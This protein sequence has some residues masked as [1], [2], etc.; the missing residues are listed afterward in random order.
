MLIYFEEKPYNNLLSS[1]VVDIR[2]DGKYSTANI[3]NSKLI[4]IY[5]SSMSVFAVSVLSLLIFAML[6]THS[7][8]NNYY[9][10]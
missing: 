3:L 2:S 1:S 9:Y 5:S 10:K 8:S 4:Y 7:Y 6:Q